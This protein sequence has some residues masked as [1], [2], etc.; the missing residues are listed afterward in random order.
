MKK[1]SLLVLGLLCLNSV[2]AQSKE[3]QLLEKAEYLYKEKQHDHAILKLN[4]LI[5]IN[6]DFV[7]AYLYRADNKSELNQ[8]DS[9]LKDYKKVIQLDSLNM[10]ALFEIA[11][12][13]SNLL[14]YNTAILYYNKSE[15][16]LKSSST[17]IYNGLMKRSFLKET[18]MYMVEENDILFN[19]GL[20]YFALKEYLM[21][22]KNFSKITKKGVDADSK[23]MLGLTLLKLKKFKESCKELDSAIILGSKKAMLI[24][25][26]SCS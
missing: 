20:S 16:V 2:K 1:I 23:Y 15:D 3:I 19:R 9:A 13:Y 8:F 24:K 5:K 10:L 11:N 26:K 25:A 21:A 6:P 14:D 22:F 4:E 18:T 7:A 12:N 17:P